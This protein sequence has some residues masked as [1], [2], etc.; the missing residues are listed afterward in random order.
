MKMREMLNLRQHQMKRIKK[1]TDINN[2]FMPIATIQS[3]HKLYILL[4][5]S[6]LN[7]LM[8]IL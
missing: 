3:A 7:C 5:N 2:N 1:I 8:F 4:L 6:N